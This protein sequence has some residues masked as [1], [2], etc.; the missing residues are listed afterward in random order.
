MAEIEFSDANKKPA[1][2]KRKRTSTGTE[3][4]LSKTKRK[5]SEDGPK[6]KYDVVDRDLI[7]QAKKDGDSL[8]EFEA[9]IE[10]LVRDRPQIREDEQ[11]KVYYTMFKSVKKLSRKAARTAMVSPTG[12]NIYP[13][14][15][16]YNQL[17]DL[18]A[19]IRALK[20]IT[21]LTYQIDEDVLVPYTQQTSAIFMEYYQ[22]VR[23]LMNKDIPQDKL[24]RNTSELK[25]ITKQSGVSLQAA[26][27]TALQKTNFVL[28]DQ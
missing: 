24:E 5:R 7:K 21:E 23:D 26:Y 2:R 15:Q 3:V 14:I 16:L 8:D 4:A 27:A 25:K 6:S 1:K 13:L 28:A 10:R 18:V 9:S 19:D 20:N 11:F 22:S 12:R 17:R